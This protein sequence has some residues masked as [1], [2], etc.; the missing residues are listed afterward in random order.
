VTSSKSK[1]RE[2]SAYESSERLLARE[3]ANLLAEDR[4]AALLAELSEEER[5][6]L[7]AEL[8]SDDEQAALQ[9]LRKLGLDIKPKPARRSKTR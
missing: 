7:L 3:I 4:A 2:Q 1:A 5:A 9:A 6:A 8:L